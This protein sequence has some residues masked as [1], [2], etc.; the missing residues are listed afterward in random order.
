M[1]TAHHINSKKG[2]AGA[3]EIQTENSAFKTHFTIVA[4][5]V[6]IQGLF[7]GIKQIIFCFTVETLYSRSM[8]TMTCMIVV[9]AIMVICCH[10]RNY[11]LSFFP[12][13][14]GFPYIIITVIAASFYTVT[15]FFVNGFSVQNALM[16]L[17]GSIVT[18]VFEEVLFRGVIWNKLNKHYTKEWKTYL[19]VT[20][21]FA[22]WHIGYAVGIYLW[23]GGNLLNCVMMKVMAGAIFGLITGAIRFKT[24]NCYSGMLVHGILNVLG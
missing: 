5:L 14:F 12:T 11:S 3:C 22:L 8:V 6:F 17:Y 23:K 21:L 7:L 10:Y 18:P 24:R 13:V 9:F 4:W 1:C 2:R 16:L 19:M 20:M 15:L